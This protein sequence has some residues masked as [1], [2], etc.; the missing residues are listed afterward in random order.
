M[1][2]AVANS[3]LALVK[4]WGKADENAKRPASG[5]LSVTLEGLATAAEVRFSKDD[6]RDAVEGL[7]EAAETRVRD[8]LE[9]FRGR[10]GIREQASVS[11]ASNFPVA[12]GLASSASTFAALATAAVHAAGISIPDA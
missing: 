6:R 5:S 8:F 11:V 2:W 7:P 10:F 4:Y 9:R 3:N 1:T 12:A